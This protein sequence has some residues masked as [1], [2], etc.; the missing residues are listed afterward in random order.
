[1]TVNIVI[2]ITTKTERCALLCLKE[3]ETFLLLQQAEDG[4]KK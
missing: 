2:F 4:E 3:H 1:M